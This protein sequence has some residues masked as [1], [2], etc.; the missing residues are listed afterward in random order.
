MP[1]GVDPNDIE[2]DMAIWHDFYSM[3]TVLHN[4][5]DQATYYVLKITYYYLHRYKI[6][7]RMRYQVASEE[8]KAQQ[9]GIMG[10]ENITLSKPTNK[11]IQPG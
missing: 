11:H 2:F 5:Q 1:R 7:R 9:L 4:K 3:Q 10:L 6:H 8:R